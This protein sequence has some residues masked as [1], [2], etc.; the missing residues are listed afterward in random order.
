ME[1]LC[2]QCGDRTRRNGCAIYCF[3]CARHREKV[4]SRKYYHEKKKGL[5]KLCLFCK[6]EDAQVHHAD[7]N[8]N[9]NEPINLI[10]LCNR[11]HMNVH[12]KI[13]KPFINKMVMELEGRDYKGTEIA[14][15]IGL[16][17]Q[18]IYKILNKDDKKTKTK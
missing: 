18:R 10:P 8:R 9:N 1:K 7:M 17:K 5:G 4:N 13:L 2:K 3:A 15:I 6:E 12:F 16:S 14:K 11:C